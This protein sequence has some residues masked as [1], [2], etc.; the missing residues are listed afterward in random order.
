MILTP[1]PKNKIMSLKI[2]GKD[3]CFSAN[4]FSLN[5][6][7]KFKLTLLPHAFQEIMLK[8][9]LNFYFQIS[10]WCLEM[11]YEGL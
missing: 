6:V 8:I 4:N 9:N 3:I 1:S 10:L 5:H 7:T 2:V 11:F